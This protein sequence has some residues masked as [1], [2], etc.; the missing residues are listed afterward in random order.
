MK[1]N[2]IMP[3]V[4][5]SI[6][7]CSCGLVAPAGP[8]D[9]AIQSDLKL[10]AAQSCAVSFG[11]P[12]TPWGSRSPIGRQSLEL[13][14]FERQGISVEKDVA[15]VKAI[16]VLWV[17]GQANKSVNLG[18]CADKPDDG[19]DRWLSAA[20]IG[21]MDGVK[22]FLPEKPFRFEITLVYRRYDTGWSLETFS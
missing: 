22:T 21:I 10:L 11:D 3:V 17:A 8:T 13:I 15:R 9:S 2:T 19:F 7:L 6:F 12:Y 18:S 5:V 20:G 1:L 14:S 16:A 4:A